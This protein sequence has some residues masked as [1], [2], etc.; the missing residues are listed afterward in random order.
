MAREWSMAVPTKTVK[1]EAEV[2]FEDY[3]TQ[4]GLRFE[5]EALPGNRKPDYLIHAPSGDCVVE[6]KQIEE[7]KSLTPG[8]FNPDRFVRAKID[9]ARKQFREYK[10]LPCSLAIFSKSIFGPSDPGVILSAAFGPGHQQ[11]GRDGSRVDPR[12]TFY[13]FLNKSELPPERQF[14]A[15]AML[16]PAANTTFSAIILVIRYELNE[17]HLEVWRRL[18]AKQETGQEVRPND[19][20]RLLNELGPALVDKR[21]FGGTIRVVVIENRHARIPFPEDLFRGP[22]DQRWGWQDGLCGPIWIGSELERLA[23]DGVPF[24]ML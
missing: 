4:R 20:L 10:H 8:G 19:Q 14:L 3:L 18:Y 23:S 9:D 15:D 5:Y 11:Y 13:R 12:P 24:Y 17:L 6:M 1:T 22:F 21:R 2:G 16:S 7:P